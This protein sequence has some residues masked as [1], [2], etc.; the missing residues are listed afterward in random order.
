MAKIAKVAIKKPSGKVVSEPMGKRHVDLH[1]S[2][3]RGF[4]TTTGKFV[5]RTEGAKIANKANQVK[6]KV[7][8][9]H[10]EDLKAYKSRSKSK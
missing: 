7:T 1:T 3:Q 10:S 8:H 4:V 2:G 5:N 6:S 9:L